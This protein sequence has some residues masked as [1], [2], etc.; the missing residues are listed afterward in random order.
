LSLHQL[1]KLLPLELRPHR[2]N[3]LL[4]AHLEGPVQAALREIHVWLPHMK[5]DALR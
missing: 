2:S 1:P 5:L 4:A 3:Q